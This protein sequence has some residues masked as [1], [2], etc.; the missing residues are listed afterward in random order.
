MADI[1]HEDEWTDEDR[2]RR[3]FNGTTIGRM[4]EKDWQ[5]LLGV[6]ADVRADE[7]SKAAWIERITAKA[8]AA[9]VAAVLGEA[10]LCHLPPPRCFHVQA[11]K[12]CTRYLEG[13]LAEACAIVAWLRAKHDEDPNEWWPLRA[14]ADAIESRPNRQPPSTRMPPPVRPKGDH[15]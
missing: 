2:I 5:S 11:G 4:A 7:R 10:D 14:V 6:L 15:E 12:P 13:A 9:M 8:D 1:E 3:W